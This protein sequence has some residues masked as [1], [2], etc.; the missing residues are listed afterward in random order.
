MPYK[1]FKNK[2]LKITYCLKEDSNTHEW[3]KEA[4]SGLNEKVSNMDEKFSKNIEILER[5]PQV[6]E[7]KNSITK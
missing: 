5:K 7:M 3:S 2:L 6:L 1:E 4:N